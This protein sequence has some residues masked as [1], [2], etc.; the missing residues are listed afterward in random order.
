M[1]KQEARIAKMES[2]FTLSPNFIDHYENYTSSRAG[3]KSR[4]EKQG[5]AA[6]MKRHPTRAESVLNKEL[7]WL[8]K[9]VAR[10]CGKSAM[11]YNRQQVKGGYIL[12]FYL[13]RCRLAIEVDGPYHN[14]TRQRAYDK[15]RDTRLAK[16]DVKTMRFTNEE[17][18]NDVVMVGETIRKEAMM[19]FVP[20]HKRRGKRSLRKAI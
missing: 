5:F 8:R 20:Q 17:V 10:T 14:T 18:L 16:I 19:R 2:K 15:R 7:R 11:L 3:P 1:T 12:D 4:K 9:E 6:T 13:L